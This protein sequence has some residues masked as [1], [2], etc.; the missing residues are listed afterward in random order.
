MLDTL[1]EDISR[2]ALRPRIVVPRFLPLPRLV[3]AEVQIPEVWLLEGVGTA[4]PATHHFQKDPKLSK[5][6]FG[7]LIARVSKGLDGLAPLKQV[8]QWT[9]CDSGH[10]LRN[11]FPN[12]DEGT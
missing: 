6:L 2:Q 11:G 3:A 5:T 12:K 4:P 1:D 7:T 10:L 9:A 8:G